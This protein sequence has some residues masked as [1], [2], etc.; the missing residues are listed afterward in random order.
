M[1]IDDSYC[2]TP[3]VQFEGRYAR[4][5]RS[6]IGRSHLEPSRRCAD[7]SSCRHPTDI[8]KLPR[9]DQYITVRKS[10]VHTRFLCAL[11][12]GY[13]CAEILTSVPHLVTWALFP[14]CTNY[15]SNAR[16]LEDITYGRS[17]LSLFEFDL[18]HRHNVRDLLS[19][20]LR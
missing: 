4:S 6:Y 1:Y 10:Y 19:L 17:L 12:S 18:N 2:M 20:S 15:V 8:F 11:I 13:H 16:H 14:S 3:A 7:L 9:S 5:L